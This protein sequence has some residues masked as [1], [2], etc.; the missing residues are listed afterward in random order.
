MPPTLPA[1]ATT[2]EPSIPLKPARSAEGTASHAMDIEGEKHA[3]F[4]AEENA[5]HE[6]QCWHVAPPLLPDAGDRQRPPH[7]VHVCWCTLRAS[8]W[9][10][11]TS[12]LSGRADVVSHAG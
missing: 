3:G 11:D 12:G 6:S 9:S 7:R 1:A 4:A 2:G 5:S 10:C 8:V